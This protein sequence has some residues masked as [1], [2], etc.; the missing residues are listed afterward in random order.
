MIGP[1]VLS[2]VT[3][4]AELGVNGLRPAGG[5]TSRLGG[6]GWLVKEAPGPLD[7]GHYHGLHLI[8]G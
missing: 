4:R 7:Q 3:S 6:S 5:L 1:A 8:P 2:P